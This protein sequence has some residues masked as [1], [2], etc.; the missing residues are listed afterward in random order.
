MVD[1]MNNQ[2]LTKLKFGLAAAVICIGMSAAC[3]AQQS[4]DNSTQLIVPAVL[5]LMDEA[6]APAPSAGVVTKVI[7]KE[8]DRVKRGALLAK[9][10]DSEARLA[11]EAAKLDVAIAR[12]LAENDVP[13]RY[14]SK[15][16]EVADAELRRSQESIRQFAKSVSQS[17]IDVERLTAEKARLEQEKATQDQQAAKLELELKENRF[18]AARVMYERRQIRAPIDGMIVEVEVHQGAWLE[19]GQKAFRLVGIDRL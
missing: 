9:L 6:D 17:Q 10:D 2:L 3:I 4:N 1:Q 13:L 11:V 7:A 15:A 8:G 14:A 16:A 19:A 5:R 18:R 12:Q